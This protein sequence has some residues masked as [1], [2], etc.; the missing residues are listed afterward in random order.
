MG[1]SEADLDLDVELRELTRSHADALLVNLNLCEAELKTAIAFPP[2]SVPAPCEVRSDTQANIRASLLAIA[3]RSFQ[4]LDLI[5]RPLHGDHQTRLFGLVAT[6]TQLQQRRRSI[7][8]ATPLPHL[9]PSLPPSL[10]RLAPA[11]V[12][13][14][15]RPPQDYRSLERFSCPSSPSSSRPRH[16]S[17]PP[18]LSLSHQRP[19]PLAPPAQPMPPPQAASRS[20]P[21]P[22]RAA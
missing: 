4:L 5:S 18:T 10:L 7:D 15:C 3:P 19:R 16:S 1:A 9:S 6:T 21:R 11:A 12:C 13:P 17:T 22:P 14:T 8:T 20:P 2:L